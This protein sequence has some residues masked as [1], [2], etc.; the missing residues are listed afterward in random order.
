MKKDNNYL[1]FLLLSTI[2]I[3]SSCQSVDAENVARYIGRPTFANPCLANGDGTCFQNGE[4][5]DTTNMICGEA[6]DF[7]LIQTHLE[8]VEFRL[9]RCLRSGRR[10]K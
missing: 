1:S 5:R 4:L 6:D 3:V 8:N 9:Y 7:D 2:L 10:C